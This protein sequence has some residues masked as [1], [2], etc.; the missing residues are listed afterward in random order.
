MCSWRGRDAEQCLS[1]PALSQL[2]WFGDSTNNVKVAGLTGQLVD[3]RVT[4]DL[5]TTDDWSV[6]SVYLL[7]PG[8]WSDARIFAWVFDIADVTVE[9]D[10]SS[11]LVTLNMNANSP[12]L[13]SD[14]SNFYVG[15]D[16]I[17]SFIDSGVSDTYKIGKLKF[18][19]EPS[20]LACKMSTL[21]ELSI[22][23]I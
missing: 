14:W 1:C 8:D 10:G 13:T 6:Y 11:T 23:L 20:T 2:T 7:L 9:D 16:N 12:T 15:F 19:E 18:D 17:K 5:S 21:R 3:S 4:W 22:Y